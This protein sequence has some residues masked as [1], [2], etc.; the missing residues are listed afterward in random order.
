[1]ITRGNKVIQDRN[2]VFDFDT[3]LNDF[4]ENKLYKGVIFNEKRFGNNRNNR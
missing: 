2:Y 4:I 1:M 3:L